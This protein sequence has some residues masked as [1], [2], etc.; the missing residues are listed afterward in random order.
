MRTGPSFRLSASK[1]MTPA[2]RPGYGLSYSAY[3]SPSS[4]ASTPSGGSFGTSMY[5]RSFTGGSFG[6]SVGKSFSATNLRQQFNTDGEGVL[7]PGAFAPGSSRYSSG[8]IRRLTVDRSLKADLF[9]RPSSQQLA[10]PPPQNG[11]KNNQVN[12]T[13]NG[14]AMD[15]APS[16]D[17]SHRARAKKVSFSQDTNGEGN[18][19]QSDT[20]NNTGTSA[21][22]Q[23]A[24]TSGQDRRSLNIGSTSATETS[25]G[26]KL[27][28]VAEADETDAGQK[29]TPELAN[30]ALPKI[31]GPPGPYWMKPT[32]AEI[33]NMPRTEKKHFRGFQVGRHG[34]GY[35]TF[36]EEV[37]LDTIPV[38]DLWGPGKI[39]EIDVRHISVYNDKN[40]DKNKDKYPNPKPPVGQ[41]LNVPS[42]LHI[43][44]A[45]PR[46]HKKSVR[47]ADPVLYDSH[48]KTLKAIPGTAFVS[49]DNH[50]GTWTFKVA[51][52]SR[53]GLEYDND[54]SDDDS[55][56]DEHGRLED[57]PSSSVVGVQNNRSDANSMEVDEDSFSGDDT[58][59]FRKKTVPGEF[60]EQNAIDYDADDLF[61]ADQT[62]GEASG[63]ERSAGSESDGS[64]DEINMAGT[65]PQ[66]TTPGSI[67][68][69]PVKAATQIGGRAW[70]TPGKPL[71][72]LDDDWAEH[73]Q[74]TISP[75]KQ[76]RDFLRQTQNNA[77]LDRALSPIKAKPASEQNEIRTNID[78]MNS[79]FG[80]HEERMARSRGKTGGGR[81]T[82]V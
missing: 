80:D 24:E 22:H 3:G 1:P 71:I 68:G 21:Q 13:A 77:P 6:K 76:D 53:Y 15:D 52:F 9:N 25:N 81:R 11:S 62:A 44:N 45:W 64:D 31:Q 50:T 10:L 26:Q 67:N 37:D 61:A 78:L 54:E 30:P 36:D 19:N 49:Y 27:A 60:D 38:H 69:T 20:D 48:I 70:D 29:Q 17:Q 2:R 66:I 65:F 56:R 73:L 4:V 63:S 82:E 72:E 74:R 47:D 28:V 35:L 34:Y 7:S 16:L 12:G 40:K 33:R 42:T 5:S 41:G 32:L 14:D 51:H 79:L 46:Q 55:S 18:G 75:R 8:S 59:E 43:A 58:F 23:S 57:Q 39:I